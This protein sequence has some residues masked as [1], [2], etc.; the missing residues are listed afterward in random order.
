MNISYEYDKY[1]CDVNDIINTINKYGV[2]IIPNVLNERECDNIVNG[3]W[4]YFEHITKQWNTPISR[5]NITTWNQ[6]YNL[7]PK[8]SMLFQNWGIG[9]SQVCWDVRQNQKIIDIFS[10]LWK[11]NNE[12]LLV[13]FD[14]ASF[15]I[16]P[17]YTNKGWHKNN[18]FHSDQSYTRNNLECIQ[19]WVTGLDVNEGDATL[20]IMESSNKYHEEFAKHY[21]ITDKSDWYKLND[22]QELFYL[23]KGC[24]YKKI[25]CPKGSLVLW[26]SRTIHC[27]SE[28]MK[29]RLKDNFRAVVY[30]CYL[31]RHLCDNKN[32]IKKQKAFKELRTTNHYPCKIKLFPKLPYTYGK[33]LMAITE[34]EPPI[35]NNLGIKLAGF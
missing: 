16:P 8:H 7:Y 5:N 32:L 35:L 6:I 33:P 29:N 1:V 25:K 9:Q 23:N 2:A 17:E 14:G 13:S 24:S 31:P 4:N 18:W 3:F 19:S 11:C 12:D 28:P 20:A 34:I 21:K 27:G 10:Q 30:V 26:D 15:N 22:E